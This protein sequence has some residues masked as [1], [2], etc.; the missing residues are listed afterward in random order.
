MVWPKSHFAVWWHSASST[1]FRFQ[2]VHY[3]QSQPIFWFP[4]QILER[5]AL[6]VLTDSPQCISTNFSTPWRGKK[7]QNS[8]TQMIPQMLPKTSSSALVAGSRDSVM[9]W[10]WWWC[11]LRAF[12]SGGIFYWCPSQSSLLRAE[13]TLSLCSLFLDLPTEFWD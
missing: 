12:L 10:L 11:P 2:S 9:R 7:G 1:P 4:T 8:S 13:Q 6:S 3:L 5:E